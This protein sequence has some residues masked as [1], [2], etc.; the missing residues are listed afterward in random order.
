MKK[1]RIFLFLLFQSPSFSILHFFSPSLWLSIIQIVSPYACRHLNLKL[2]RRSSALLPLTIVLKKRPI[3]SNEGADNVLICCRILIMIRKHLK[4]RRSNAK[5]WSANTKLFI[6]NGMEWNPKE[7]KA[8]ENNP[9][10]MLWI[11]IISHMCILIRI[12]EHP[13][14]VV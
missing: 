2:W 9:E 4:K 7:E 6:E 12:A 10:C 3:G 14:N 8:K 1:K 11:W 13:S 5:H